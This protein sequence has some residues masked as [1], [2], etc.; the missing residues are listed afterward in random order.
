MIRLRTSPETVPRMTN[1]KWHSISA[2]GPFIRFKILIIT[3][4]HAM[5]FAPAW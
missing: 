2:I 3:V 5:L 1:R 4:G